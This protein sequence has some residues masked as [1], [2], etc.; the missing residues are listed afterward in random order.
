MIYKINVYTLNK[1]SVLLRSN[2]SQIFVVY[3]TYPCG[4]AVALF[5]MLF[6][7]VQSLNYLTTLHTR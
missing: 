4:S 5:I 6:K 3:I 7:I 1:I 2:T